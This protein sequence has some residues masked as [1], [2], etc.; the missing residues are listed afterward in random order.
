MVRREL[1]E[2]AFLFIWTCWEGDISQNGKIVAFFLH[3]MMQFLVLCEF[4]FQVYKFRCFFNCISRIEF[5]AE[6]AF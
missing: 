3:A 6:R 2:A 1:G 5:R 4:V